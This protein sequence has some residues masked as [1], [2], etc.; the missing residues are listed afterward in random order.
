MSDKTIELI[1]LVI[2][3]GEYDDSPLYKSF[4]SS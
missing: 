3:K 1:D 2:Q 4:T